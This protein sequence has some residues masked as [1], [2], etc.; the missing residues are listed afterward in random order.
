M[1]NIIF[2]ITLKQNN[3]VLRVCLD[4]VKNSIKIEKLK[5]VKKIVKNNYLDKREK[6][7]KVM[8]FQI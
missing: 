7:E 6:N 1:L 4:R 8:L 3:F 2:R 5:I